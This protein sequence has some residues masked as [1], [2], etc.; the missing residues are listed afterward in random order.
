MVAEPSDRSAEAAGG[1]MNE[2]D[3]H[4]DSG[5]DIFLFQTSGEGGGCYRMPRVGGM[6]VCG[7]RG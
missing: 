7:P 4:T 2:A 3:E 5:P 6:I 1:T